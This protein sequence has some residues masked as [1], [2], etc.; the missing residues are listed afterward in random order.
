MFERECSLQRRFQKILEEAPAPGLA[1][2]LRR[3]LAEA[4]LRLARRAGYV[5]AGTVEFLVAPD[6]RFYFLETNTRL[7]VEHPVT[8]M[9]TGLDLVEWQ[10]RV[11]AGE[12]LPLGQ[13][14][15]S[16]QGHAIE[17]RINAEDPTRAFAASTGRLALFRLPDASPQLRL[18]TGIR[19]ADAVT[20]FYDS[21]IAKIIVWGDDRQAAVTR[22][23][24]ALGEVR[25]AGVRSNARYLAAVA[26]SPEFAAGEF[27]VGFLER[28]HERF[29]RAPGLSRD[30]V[31]V[32]ALALLRRRAE[33]AAALA[34][35]DP[36][37]PWALATG[38][39]LHADGE[40]T[41]TF[42][43]G[44]GTTSVTVR[45]RPSGWLLDLPDGPAIAAL[46]GDGPDLV[47]EIAG[48]QMRA[49]VAWEGDAI[50]VDLDGETTRFEPD[51][52]PGGGRDDIAAPSGL[53]APMPGTVIDVLARPGMAVSRGAALVV[54]EAM[55]MEQ[56]VRAPVDGVVEAVHVSRGM[57]V[58]EG[59]ELI[60][61]RSGTKE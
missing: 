32:A 9:I 51:E 37:S 60:S 25:I 19:Q 8:E 36:H 40:E 20:P 44:D 39:R 59:T 23:L 2:G 46:V 10:L 52:R 5:G 22:L 17:A 33:T 16:R 57:Q 26:A 43:S 58:A 53:A 4:A 15:I 12:P 6:E 14:R 29:A 34:V 27:D 45:H 11:A 50:L 48:R 21:L 7:Q 42:R 61:F 54:L 47:V 1:D 55:K 49:T 13:D 3:D 56:T 41:L 35:A 18:E 38:W 30:A 24:G 31:A 28:Q